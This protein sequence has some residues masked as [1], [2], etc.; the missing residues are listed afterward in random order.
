VTNGQR[1][2]RGDW[3]QHGFTQAL[4]TR[5]LAP[6]ESVTHDVR[7]EDPRPGEYT[8][9]ATLAASNVDVSA[10]EPFVVAG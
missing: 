10:Q 5:T 6:E 8:A 4:V 3:V 9:E 2:R 1:A 7:W